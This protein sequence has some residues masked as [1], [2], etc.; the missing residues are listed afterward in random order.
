MKKALFAAAIL[1]SACQA[2]EGGGNGSAEATNGAAGGEAKGGEARKGEAG[3]TSLLQ[4]LE[5][6]SDHATLANAVKAAGLTET[7]SGAQPYTLF[8]PNEA[9]FQKLPAGTANSL[10]AP[11]A[12][13]QLVSLLT[14]HIVPGQVTA[15]DLGKAI[16]R[17]KGKAQLATVGGANLSFS[18]SGD[19][20]LVSDGSGA[21]ARLTGAEQVQSNGVIHSLDSVL[22]GR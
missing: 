21:Q 22:K 7:L 20:I 13:G 3:K 12:K 5:Q 15:Q 6:S 8:A 18:R 4:A 10:L 9:A 19:A 11:E 14:S 16:D 2:E 17:G 1:L